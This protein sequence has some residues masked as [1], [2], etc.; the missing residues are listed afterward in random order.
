[1]HEFLKEKLIESNYLVNEIDNIVKGLACDKHA[2]FRINRNKSSKEDIINILN[3]NKIS[4][5]LND[6]F[7]DAIILTDVVTKNGVTIDKETNIIIE[8][9]DIY[10]DG[11]IYMQSLS[12]MK[13]VYLLSPKPTENILDM[14]AAPGG[15]TTMIASITNNKANI[16]ATELHKDR[17][18]RLL[19]NIKIQGANVYAMQKN[20]IDLDENLKFDKILLDAPCTGSGTFDLRNENYLKY[21]T[22]VLIEKVTKTQRKLILKASKL[23]KK[24]GILVYS[25]CSLLKKENEDMVSFAKNKGFKPDGDIIKI[26][27]NKYFEGFFIAR[28]IRE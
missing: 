17:Y 22:N 4:F 14:C 18:E 27:P 9:L 26:M 13:P 24:G 1:M 12:S 3:D 5:E 2:S 8:D 21:F 25:T 16:T 15:K 23:L 19:F 11:R 10:R 6:E 28:F 7:I 20:A